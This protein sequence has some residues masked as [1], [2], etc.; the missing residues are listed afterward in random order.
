M[1]KSNK[2][3]S[4]KDVAG[5]EGTTSSTSGP[6]KKASNGAGKPIEKKNMTQPLTGSE[7]KPWRIGNTYERPE[8]QDAEELQKSNETYKRLSGNKKS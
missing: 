2:K 7:W 6:K 3:L 8:N 1:A 4:L 5:V